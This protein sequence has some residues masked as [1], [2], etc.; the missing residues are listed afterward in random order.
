[1][2]DD[3][4]FPA[5]WERS[6]SRIRN[7]RPGQEPEPEDPEDPADPE[8]AGGRRRLDD[9][10]GDSPHRRLTVAELISRIGHPGQATPPRGDTGEGADGADDADD[11]ADTS[12]DA[13][14]ASDA[15]ESSK[16]D[17]PHDLGD[18]PAPGAADTPEPSEPVP[19]QAESADSAASDAPAEQPSWIPS[20]VPRAVAGSGGPPA[21]RN[22]SGRRGNY[23]MRGSRIV[24]T[25][26][27]VLALVGTGVV[28]SYLRVTDSNYT[29]ISALDENS[30]DVRDPAGQY[31]DENYLIVGTDTRAGANAD[32]GAGTSDQVEGARSD[33]IILVNIPASRERVVAVSFPR[34]L[35]ID[36][37]ACAQWDNGAAEYADHV[38]PPAEDVKLNSAYAFGGPR[39]L[40]KV[41]QKL[42]GL[43]VNHFIGMDF[44][45]FESMVDTVG[46]VEVCTTRPLVDRQLGTIIP[47]AGTHTISGEKALEYVRARKVPAEGNGDYGRIRRQQEFLS[48]L[49]RKA[50]SNNVLLD[51]GKLNT[52]INEFTQA[53]FGDNLNTKSLI[54]LARSLQNVDADQVTFLTVPTAG[55]DP[56]GNETPRLADIRNLFDAIIDDQPLPGEGDSADTDTDTDTDADSD[57][58]GSQ[59]E[60]GTGD[61]GA[62]AGSRASGA[63]AGDASAGTS[64]PPVHAVAPGSVSVAV[65]NASTVDGFAHS[66]AQELSAQG[67]GIY[68]I[69]NRTAPVSTTVIEFSGDHEAEAATVASAYP[70]AKL[71]RTTGLGSVVEVLLSDDSQRT[72]GPPATAGSVLTPILAADSNEEGSVPQ[73]ISTVNAGDSSCAG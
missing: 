57:G 39:C 15:S 11:T 17:D 27:S 48:S 42:S 44:A 37:P 12:G 49:L 45:G 38:D 63:S 33:T 60:S 64:A 54:T 58:S 53:S 56:W 61:G 1:M 5:P 52:F 23:W 3:H 65:K 32:V 9:D 67:F 66:T 29:R 69:G 71:Q 30:T 55:T 68:S 20:A 25:L 4:R 8:D 41:I 2:T 40:V 31:G 62:S 72:P 50:L 24:I 59:S 35:N 7:E 51:P 73:D 18:E 34:D 47:T 46:G 14:D 22:G 6:L 21:G 13:A 36:R 26:V 10:V 28:W 16:P 19:V 43:K 70:D